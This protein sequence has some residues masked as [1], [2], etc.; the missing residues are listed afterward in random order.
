MKCAVSGC[1]NEARAK[2]FCPTHLY[3]LKKFGS[4]LENLPVTL[5]KTGERNGRW[6][7]GQMV[8]KKTGRVLIYTPGHPAAINGRYVYRYRLVVEKRLGRF[9]KPD[10]HIH[11]INGIK[12]DDRDENLQVMSGSEH[13]KLHQKIWRQKWAR[14]WEQCR[15]CGTKKISHMAKGLCS[16][17]YGFKLYSGKLPS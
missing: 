10:E 2:G 15:H 12:D 3:R 13:A 11:H 4:V 9:L 5:K 14:K 16:K 17:C 1:V 6:K 8:D 7:G